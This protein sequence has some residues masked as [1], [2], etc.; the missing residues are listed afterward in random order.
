MNNEKF[1]N[2][3]CVLGHGTTTTNVTENHKTS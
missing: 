3:H 1:D 2:I